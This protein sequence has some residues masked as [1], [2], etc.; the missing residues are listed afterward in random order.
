MLSATVNDLRQFA[1]RLRQESG[2][3]ALTKEL[4]KAIRVA[5]KELCDSAKSRIKGMSSRSNGRRAGGSLRAKIA[6]K[7][8]VTVKVTGPKVGVRIG[9]MTSGMPRGFAA[10]GSATNDAGWR[11]PVFGRGVWVNQSGLPGWFDRTLE[12]GGDDT[13]RKIQ[14]VINDFADR[15]SN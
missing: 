3:N 2:D 11:H 8:T 6:S 15:L 1:T 9:V 5:A 7:T 12:A 10:A 4:T 13:R 14:D